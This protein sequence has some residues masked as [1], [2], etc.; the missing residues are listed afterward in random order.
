MGSDMV[1]QA[2]AEAVKAVEV[3]GKGQAQGQCAAPEDLAGH[4][5]GGDQHG[6]AGLGE[7]NVCGGAR[8]VGGA[9]DGDADIGALEGGRVV[10]A[11]AGHAHSKA[12]LAQRL[13]DAVLVLGVHLCGGRGRSRVRSGARESAS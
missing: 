13:N 1:E 9:L 11:V 12:L 4:D 5:D 6:E 2:Q 3:Q 7:H 10:D 8:G